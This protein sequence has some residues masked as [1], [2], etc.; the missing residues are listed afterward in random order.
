MAAVQGNAPGQ[1]MAEDEALG[2]VEWQSMGCMVRRWKAAQVG[3]G[4]IDVSCETETETP[5]GGEA[6][7]LILVW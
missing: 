7:F 5:F 6:R 2:Q 3:R 1:K 4:M